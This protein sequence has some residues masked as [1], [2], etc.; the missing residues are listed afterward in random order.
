MESLGLTCDTTFELHSIS[1][2]N[3]HVILK[4]TEVRYLCGHTLPPIKVSVAPKLCSQGPSLY[5]KKLNKAVDK[6]FD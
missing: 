3:F 6:N 5:L 4:M 1:S 2:N